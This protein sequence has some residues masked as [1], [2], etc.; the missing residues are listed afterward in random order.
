MDDIVS[1]PKAPRVPLLLVTET[2][3]LEEDQALNELY[4]FMKGRSEEAQGLN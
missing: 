4:D 2:L 3:P 1:K